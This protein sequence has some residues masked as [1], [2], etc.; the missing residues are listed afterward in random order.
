MSYI[1]NFVVEIL[2]VLIYDLGS[3]DHTVNDS[4]LRDMGAGLEVQINKQYEYISDTL[5]WPI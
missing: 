1:P 5:S 3:T 2:S 4:F